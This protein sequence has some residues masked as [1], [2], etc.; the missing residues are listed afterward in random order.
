MASDPKVCHQLK[1]V[2]RTS[3]ELMGVTLGE[4]LRHVFRADKAAMPSEFATLLLRLDDL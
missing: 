1:V 4:G 3:D 2:S